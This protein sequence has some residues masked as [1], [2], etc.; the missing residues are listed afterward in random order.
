MVNLFFSFHGRIN[1][2]KFWLGT[3]SLFAVLATIILSL[4]L[5]D[6]K[7]E[8]HDPSSAEII[9]ASFGGLIFLVTLYFHTCLGIKRFHDRNKSG[10]WILV[11]FVPAIGSLWYFVETGFLKGTEGVNQF[12]EDPLEASAVLA[13]A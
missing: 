8:S 12:G 10:L 3:I 1:R 5:L 6:L 2:S 9:V 4:V 7:N 11:Q 13:R